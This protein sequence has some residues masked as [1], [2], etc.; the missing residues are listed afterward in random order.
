MGKYE[1]RINGKKIISTEGM[2]DTVQI[3][4]VLNKIAN[5]LAEN[6]R[7]LRKMYYVQNHKLL[8]DDA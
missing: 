4:F 1:F 5:E 3:I 2:N 6:N 8:K 7:I